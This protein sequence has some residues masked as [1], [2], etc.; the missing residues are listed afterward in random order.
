MVRVSISDIFHALKAVYFHHFFPSLP[1]PM[2]S[3][4]DFLL[5]LPFADRKYERTP[6]ITEKMVVQLAKTGETVTILPAHKEEDVPRGLLE[7]CLDEFNYVID[8]GRTYPH[9]LQMTYQEYM[10]YLFEGFAAIWIQGEYKEEWM[11]ES[12]EFWNQKFLGYFY[13]KPN[14]IGRCSHVCNAGFIVKHTVRGKGLGV[15]MGTKYL[16]LAPRL[17]YVYSVFNLVFETNEASC[18]IWRRLGFEQ[19]G[20]VKK[21]AALKG[22]SQLVGAYMFGKDL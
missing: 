20:Y 8:E 10:A 4:F 21:V 16:E 13:I 9:Y 15:E 14:Y 17:G 11:N 2:S 1:S 19:I 5:T 18:R 12:K 22:E 3:N 6:R 7:A